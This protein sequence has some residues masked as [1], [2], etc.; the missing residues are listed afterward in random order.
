MVG[1]YLFAKGWSAS[2]SGLDNAFIVL[3]LVVLLG[4]AGR[5][6]GL[7]GRWWPTRPRGR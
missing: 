6:F 7:D 1:N 3:L 2:A 5:T 4:D